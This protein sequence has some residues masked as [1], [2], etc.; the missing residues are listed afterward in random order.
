MLKVLEM[1]LEPLEPVLVVQD[2]GL[3]KAGSGTM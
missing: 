1:T 3:Q 2:P